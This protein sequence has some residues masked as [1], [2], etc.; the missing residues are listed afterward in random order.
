MWT[1][2]LCLLIH[3]PRLLHVAKHKEI[4]LKLKKLEMY[5]KSKEIL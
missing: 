1:L 4:S 3:R 5:I 2:P